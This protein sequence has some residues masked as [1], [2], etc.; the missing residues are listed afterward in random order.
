M[1]IHGVDFPEQ[2][3]EAQRNGKLGVFAGA[4][5]SIPP[6]SN[7][8]NFEELADKVASGTLSR[9]NG[10]QIDRFLG[11][12]YDKQVKVHQRAQEILSDPGSKPNQLHIDLLQLFQSPEAVRLI[13]TN[14]D[15]HFTTA[16]TTLFGI[17]SPPEIFQ[18]P[19]IPLGGSF[20]GIVY[21]HGGVDKPA[22]RLILTDR[23]FGRAYIT[24]GWARVF[25]QGLYS[26]YTVLFVGY[27]HGDVVM[28]YLAR[29]LPPQS[30]APQRFA[31]SEAGNKEHW[32][33]LGITPIPY[34]LGTGEGK[35]TAL[36][37]ALSVWARQTRQGSLDQEQ[38][39]RSIVELPPPL[40]EE[41][42][43][44]IQASL[45]RADTARFFTR[46]AKSVEWLK[47]VEEKKFLS[48][49]FRIN[50]NTTDVDAE[51]AGWFADA[52]V[53]H[54]VGDALALL[55][56]QGD[57]LHPG[58]WSLIAR[59]VFSRQQNGVV[60]LYAARRWTPI[61]I[62]RHT[63]RCQMNYFNLILG[64]LK[65]GEEAEL[66][67]LL[68]EF[69]TRPYVSL[70]KDHFSNPTENADGEDV[71]AE[72]SI[73]GDPYWLNHIWI[74]LFKP[75]LPM[76]VDALENIVTTQIELDSRLY[77]AQ[78]KS[79]RMF[80]RLS[81]ARN[82]I[83]QSAY[84]LPHDGMDLLIDVGFEMVKWNSANRESRTDSL[85]GRW[86]D[87]SSSVLQ[88]LAIVAVAMSDHWS[89]GQK[90]QWVLDRNLIYKFGLKHEIFKVLK[91]A[92][93]D[94][95]D[96]IKTEILK[97]A[98]ELVPSDYQVPEN[99][100]L[101]ERYNLLAWLHEIA[102]ASEPTT[103]A[104]DEFQSSNPSFGKR[105]RPDLDVQMKVAGWI[106]ISTG[107]IDVDTLLAKSPTEQLEWL[108]TY[109]DKSNFLMGKDRSGLLEAVR[110]AAER[111]HEW[112]S[113]LARELSVR[114]LLKIDLW[115]SL[116]NSWPKACRNSRD[117]HE[118]FEILISNPEI[119][120]NYA[121][122]IARLLAEGAKGDAA[123]I[124]ADQLDT[125]WIISTLLWSKCIEQNA[126][127]SVTQRVDWLFTAINHPAGMVSM[128]WLHLLSKRRK[129]RGAEWAGIDSRTK[130]FLSDVLR[131]NS[132]A[133]GLACVLFGSEINFLLSI[134]SIWSKQNVVPLFDWET[135]DSQAIRAFHGFLNV[136]A[137]TESVLEYLLPC[138]RKA[139]VHFSEF[140]EVR[141]RFCQ[142]LAG[143]ACYTSINP[144]QT[145][146]LSEFLSHV[147]LKD[148]IRWALAVRHIL[149]GID[150]IGQQALWESWIS[151]YWR[152]RL[153]GV[154]VPFESEE[155][156]ETVEWTP[157]LGSAF[158][159]AVDKV[160]AG[161]QFRL[162]HSF[163]YREI[164]DTTI[165]E[166]FPTAT[167]RFFFVLLQNELELPFD[168]DKISDVVRRA[169]A[170]GAPQETLI[171]ICDRLAALGYG[172]AG[173]LSCFVK[174][175]DQN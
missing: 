75:N 59:R 32:I 148:R 83:E 42:S 28:N 12:L 107:A 58:F 17:N 119:V 150:A 9:D 143:L 151:E 8:P 163:I 36:A 6:P 156:G 116:I 55:S 48:R 27:S 67:L 131:G 77:R 153:H 158:P 20:T 102:P 63:P 113:E 62:A 44:Y 120:E 101:Y 134:D 175:I 65:N 155:L 21:L 108:L 71:S 14:F 129:E 40:D 99:V 34:Q 109:E 29:G 79:E 139:F 124:P 74:H 104:F 162:K 173:N 47:W 25:L 60:S 39:I 140:G 152:L 105:E 37:V 64:S 100:M 10:E 132:Y 69:L 81:I 122:E 30:N 94:C 61:L 137:Q 103:A 96:N 70:R 5:V 7:Y 154:P 165:P 146:W 13:T 160:V 19:A 136:G 112:G 56:R 95:G 169:V 125:A 52:F 90:S 157:Y 46:H 115:S 85:I 50:S 130:Q 170:L 141:D 66:G 145:G 18:A 118:S 164:A 92:Y 53:L 138:Y 1:R 33:S 26:S 22:E 168:T 126:P 147:E 41:L 111:R 78:S 86:I 98:K 174:G 166:T 38:R 88:R 54:H 35:H 16:A 142:Y 144:L 89:P 133:A 106:P 135:V 127:E 110:L 73:L 23:D 114:K 149:K 93:R 87:S 49:L 159:T 3:L 11:R 68:F 4:G 91:N 80:D 167:A 123:F 43:D 128:F 82:E 57:E 72:I 161:P 121:Y 24:D 172:E 45:L 2:L 171:F 51:L 15:L 117:W 76:V 97:Q 31:L 84:G